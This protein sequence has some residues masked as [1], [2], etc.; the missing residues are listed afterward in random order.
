M[1]LLRSEGGIKSVGQNP[2]W[3]RIADTDRPWL[4]S[5]ALQGPIKLRIRLASEACEAQD[6][7]VTLFFRESDHGLPSARFDVKLQGRIALSGVD[8]RGESGSPAR[9]VTKE[10]SIDAFDVLTLEL[11]P[12]DTAQPLLCGLE[13]GPLLDGPAAKHGSK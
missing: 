8:L 5:C 10:L 6:W 11:I 4:H 7:K 3:I 9:A 2:D 12:R 1:E 13:I